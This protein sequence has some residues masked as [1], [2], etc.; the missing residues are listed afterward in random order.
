MNTNTTIRRTQEETEKTAKK[1]RADYRREKADSQKKEK[2]ASKSAAY[3]TSKTVKALHE[4]TQTY[5][6]FAETIEAVTNNLEAHTWRELETKGNFDH[7][8][9]LTFI[10]EDM[11]IV[12]CDIGSEKH[13]FRAGKVMIF[14]YNGHRFQRFS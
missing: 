2:H 3:Q 9:K 6:D 8:K 5:E 13:Y 1:T 10:K 14:M 12:G 11:L 4:G 7:D